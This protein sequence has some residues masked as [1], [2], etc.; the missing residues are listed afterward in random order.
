MIPNW[1]NDTP[2][3]GHQQQNT[4][5]Q[6]GYASSS[7]Q[8]AQHPTTNIMS[9]SSNQ[10]QN[11]NQ[12]PQQK[13]SYI[14][15]NPNTTTPIISNNFNYNNSSTQN[16][17]MNLFSLP[18][19][20]S[21]LSQPQQQL[22]PPQHHYST[23]PLS[24]IPQQNL[25]VMTNTAALM[26][27]PQAN[28]IAPIDYSQYPH[29]TISQQIRQ[30]FLSPP[31]PQQQFIGQASI[32]DSSSTVR[33][34]SLLMTS[35]P[36]QFP[37]LS[38]SS[39]LNISSSTTSTSSS[40]SGSSSSYMVP[41]A[42]QDPNL[43]KNIPSVTQG[44]HETS[45]LLCKIRHRKC[46]YLYPSCTHCSKETRTFCLYLQGK[47]QKPKQHEERDHKNELFMI[48][49]EEEDNITKYITRENIDTI[50]KNV[51]NNISSI[52]CGP[53]ITSKLSYSLSMKLMAKI[54]PKAERDLLSQLL[55]VSLFPH[56]AR[57]ANRAD[58]DRAMMYILQCLCLQRIGEK[59]LG[60]E[61]F[62][63]ARSKMSAMFDHVSDFKLMAVYA[64]VVAYL[65][66]EGDKQKAEYYLNH[67]KFYVKEFQPTSENAHYLL[68][69]A[70]FS[71]SFLQSNNHDQLLTHFE[72]V[73]LFFTPKEAASYSLSKDATDA[74]SKY[75]ASSNEQMFSV[76]EPKKPNPEKTELKRQL[77]E[78]KHLV[79]QNRQEYPMGYHQLFDSLSTSS[80]GSEYDDEFTH[81]SEREEPNEN[82]ENKIKQINIAVENIKAIFGTTD[83]IGNMF[84]TFLYSIVILRKHRSF[85]G[86]ISLEAIK[87]ADLISK[88]TQYEDFIYSSFPCSVPISLACRVHL[89]SLKN[90]LITTS[91]IIAEY[92]EKLVSFLNMD[93]QALKMLAKRFPLVDQKYNKL[94][95]DVQVTLENFQQMKDKEPSRFM[96]LQHLSQYMNVF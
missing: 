26:S 73:L 51:H 54:L 72:N 57:Q 2:N 71:E 15:I 6:Q 12:Q 35:T 61:Q 22:S 94:L 44:K 69:T 27:Q 8:E 28:N 43:S 18:T 53:E 29:N 84:M 11:I 93:Y 20:R 46:D 37:F 50:Y 65:V 30:P 40:S 10:S 79:E 95:Q 38:L 80:E 31:T 42:F 89:Q 82:L 92:A 25:P 1:L 41:P 49:G 4:S 67:V 87:Y 77:S 34:S 13:A 16:S 81:T 90:I 55:K 85:K 56:I 33:A 66:G 19:N 14:R 88:T 24:Q 5:T 58:T 21:S 52:K 17:L 3:N 32:L 45:C 36:D 59:K 63:K 60:R 76:K 70:L 91:L 64:L 9:V 23:T 83:Y 74:V 48:T 86:E 78:L 75:I 39:N 7:Q 96:S 62:E 47:T 68:R